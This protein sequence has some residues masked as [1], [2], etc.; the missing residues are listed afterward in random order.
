M[1]DPKARY[2]DRVFLKLAGYGCPTI[3]PLYWIEDATGNSG[4][5]SEASALLHFHA[6]DIFACAL[7]RI[8]ACHLSGSSMIR[9]G[10]PA[11]S[12]EAV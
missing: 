7:S 6:P 3:P 5:Q 11:L 8:G 12:N 1:S 10:L 9:G 2:N 4:R